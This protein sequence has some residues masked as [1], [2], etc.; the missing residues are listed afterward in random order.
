MPLTPYHL[1]PAVL[2]GLLLRKYLDFP[3]FVLGNLL[4]DVRIGLI[5]FGIIQ[6]QTV[7]GFLHTFLYGAVLGVVLG[8]VMYALREYVGKLMDSLKLEKTEKL[9]KFLAAGVTGAWFHVILDSFLYTDIMPF[10]PSA[11]NPLLG[12]LSQTTVEMLCIISLIL[13][14]GYFFKLWSEKD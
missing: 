4:V 10:Y 8:G 7:H 6:S 2:F 13:G 1:G 5:F 12:K 3:T 11:F 9:W 14:S